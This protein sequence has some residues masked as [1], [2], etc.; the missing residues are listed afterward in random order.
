MNA[1]HFAGPARWHQLGLGTGVLAALVLLVVFYATVSGAVHRAAVERAARL[2]SAA[3]PPQRTAQRAAAPVAV[4]APG[5][6]EA[7]PRNVSYV[8]RSP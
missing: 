1:A 6:R 5:A 7:M 8:R 4:R 3:A 2:E